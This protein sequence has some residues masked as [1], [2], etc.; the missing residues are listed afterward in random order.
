MHRDLHGGN[1]MVKK[2]NKEIN[3]LKK[4]LM[5]EIMNDINDLKLKI[6]EDID[7]IDYCEEEEFDNNEPT[8][9]IRNDERTQKINIRQAEWS[10]LKKILDEDIWTELKIQ[11]K[12]EAVKTIINKKIEKIENNY[13]ME[14]TP[15]GNVIMIYDKLKESFKYYS[16]NNI[17]YRYLEVVGRKYV[18]MFNCRPLYVDMEEELRLFDEREKE[19]E[20]K[21]K[22]Q[23]E[24]KKSNP[25]EHKNVFAKFKKY[26]KDVG[27]KINMASSPKN[28]IPNTNFKNSIKIEQNEKIIFWIVDM[29]I[30]G[31]ISRGGGSFELKLSLNIYN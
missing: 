5:N 29:M 4:E 14:T 28:S 18:K 21:E 3:K 15:S 7:D 30:P 23:K 2:L 12:K 26:N 31:G 19:K 17:P 20:Q 1:V 22:E 25:V 13:V 10:K 6:I 24:T 8:L 27:S 11:S 16:D 9:K